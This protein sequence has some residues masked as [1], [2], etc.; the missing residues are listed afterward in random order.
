[1]IN[2]FTD[3]AGVGA[4]WE[5]DNTPSTNQIR[6]NYI[7]TDASGGQAVPNGSGVSIHGWGSPGMQATANV[8][9]HNLIS[10]NTGDGL[11]FCDAA[12]TQVRQNLIGVD[13]TGT[14][15][16]GNGRMGVNLGCA[17]APNNLFED[18]IIAYNAGDGIFDQPDYRYWGSLTADGHQRNRFRR[19]AIYAN[20]GLGINL[21]PRPFGT[22]DGP[23][24]NDPGDAD[25]GANK[26]QNYPVLGS[27]CTL[28]GTTTVS[29]TLNSTANAAFEIDLY[30]NQAVDPSG[31][32]EGQRFL[33]TLSVQTD[34]SGNAGFSV[35]LPAPL[36]TGEQVTATATDADGNTSEF[37]APV[38]C[39]PSTVQVRVTQATA[40]SDK[41]VKGANVYLNGQ[42]VALPNGA[43]AETDDNG[44]LLLSQARIGDQLVAV[45]PFEKQPS[46]RDAHDQWAYQPNLTSL[47]IS[48]P[49]GAVSGRKI[50]GPGVQELRLQT[51]LVLFNLVVSIEWNAQPDYM[52]QIKMAMQKASNY[53]YDVTDGQMAF[54]QVTI[55]DDGLHWDEADI[56]V[57]ARN[58]V[59]P[60]SYI[61]G[62]TSRNLAH[63]IRIGRYWNGKTGNQ[64]NW[65]EQNGYRTLVHELGHYEI[66]LAD[67]YFRYIYDGHGNAIG[68]ATSSCTGLG[69]PD[70]VNAWIMDHQYNSSELAARDVPGSWNPQTCQL[71]AQWQ[72]DG[73][74]DWEAVLAYYTDTSSPARWQFTALSLRRPRWRV[75]PNCGRPYWPFLTSQSSIGSTLRYHARSTL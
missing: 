70:A 40:T 14:Q 27:A 21:T 11:N 62:L 51:P 10:G 25:E 47:S 55:F 31:F 53:L 19:N 12:G 52:E 56:Q 69:L 6:D 46:F 33:M 68:M 7:G 39:G 16:L 67:S 2:G 54:G 24:P 13:R 3:G 18:N 9:E 75:R 1:M 66:F 64:G 61:G 29:G 58:D 41:G 63:A 34:A 60:H 38:G 50:T 42:I 45:L 44:Y 8:V 65:D 26:L 22:I 23:T 57:L 17:G 72:L 73:R 37:S 5:I 48:R 30:A 59:R 32:G 74:S 35:T 4:G 28:G 36:P 43:P 20:G 15:P 49:D 71:T